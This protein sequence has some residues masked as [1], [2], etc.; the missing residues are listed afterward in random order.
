[1]KK[2]IKCEETFEPEANERICEQCE[3]ERKE[4]AQADRATEWIPRALGAFIWCQSHGVA[5][6]EFKNFNW[7]AIMMMSG[8]N[9]ELADE[10]ERFVDEVQKL[11]EKSRENGNGLQ[12]ETAS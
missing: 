8:R 11:Q 5:A 7:Y 12:N 10:C 9:K 3:W 2:C 4:K 6:P 1:M